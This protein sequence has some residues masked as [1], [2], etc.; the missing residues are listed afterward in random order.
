MN[1]DEHRLKTR[2]L[3]V[4]ICVHPWLVCLS[5]QDGAPIRV[6]V[7]VVNV[8][9]TVYD[10]RGALIKDLAKDDFEIRENG[11]PR[12][13]RYFS[14]ETGLPLTIALL[15]DVSG[16]VRSFLQA[17]KDTAVGF[18]RGVLRPQDQAMLTGFSS[19]VVLW[20]DFT[21]SARLLGDALEGM[22]AVPF[23]GLPKDGGPMPT[24]LLYDAVSSTAT[25]KLKGLSGRK[26]I[27]IISDGIDIGSRA[28]LDGAV[29]E[30][31][32]ANA[33]VYG[34]CYPNPH[35][36]GCGY[37][38]NL[39]EPTGGRMFDLRSKTSLDEFFRIIEAEL[40]SQYSLG[41]VPSNAAGDRSFHKLQV[42]VRRTGMRVLARKGYY[43]EE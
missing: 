3:S 9:C 32:T 11:R 6:E 42:R 7:K 23:K 18:F 10:S 37:L 40:R 17:E 26:A 43:V 1:T 20:Q 33:I 2:F 29:R 36:S 12:Q 13:I 34:I 16:S 5:G 38:K 19:T 22:H 35:E 8:L 30:A 39:S 4:L 27:V 24:T 14:R 28:S 25:N 15:V 21:P 31:Q 41:F